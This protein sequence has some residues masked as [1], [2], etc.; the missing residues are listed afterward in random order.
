MFFCLVYLMIAVACC[1]F[2]FG[3]SICV[4]DLSVMVTEHSGPD[5]C[6]GGPAYKPQVKRLRW[7]RGS[8]L[9]FDTQVSRLKPGR[10]RRI[11][12]RKNSQSK[13]LSHVADLRH[14]KEP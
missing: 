7:S 12:G 4:Q 3:Y 8:V 2:C 5:S 11:S 9:A 13:S 10:S 6:S 14:V 1:W